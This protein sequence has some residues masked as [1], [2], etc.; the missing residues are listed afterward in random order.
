MREDVPKPLA[1]VIEEFAALDRNERTE[2]LIEFADRF[3]E[4]SPEIATRPFPE[5]H[6][7]PRCES[8]AFVWVS[9]ENGGLKLH[10][11]VENPQGLSAKA[12]AVILEETLSGLPGAEV[13]RVP[14]D[15]VFDIFG[16]EIS[17]G[18]GQ[19][20]MGMVA[21]TSTLAKRAA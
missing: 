12:L 3:Q 9:K 2:L 14:E 21:M 5:E 13:A 18:K 4:V 11:A 20:L 15:V 1:Q 10:F 8:E 17:M 16:R 19:G 6:R 7:V